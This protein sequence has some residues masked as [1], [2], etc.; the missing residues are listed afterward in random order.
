M[1]A[2]AARNFSLVAHQLHYAAA[3]V[4]VPWTSSVLEPTAVEGIQAIMP[5]LDVIAVGSQGPRSLWEGNLRGRA[6]L[7]TED[8]KLLEFLDEVEQK[9][10]EKRALYIS[11]RSF[12]QFFSP[13]RFISHR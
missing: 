12:V 3:G 6:G 1:P 7:K 13:L 10:G 5:S 4:V 9:R 2:Q 11:F 8:Q